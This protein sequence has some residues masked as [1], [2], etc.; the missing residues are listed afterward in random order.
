SIPGGGGSS[1]FGLTLARHVD[2]V[3]RLAQAGALL[4][5]Q[6]RFQLAEQRLRL[7]Q[8]LPHRQRA[9][10]PAAGG[11]GWIV[12]QRLVRALG[13]LVGPDGLLA[14]QRAVI[15]QE[16]V[17]LLRRER[18]E[19]REQRLQAVDAA[20]GRVDR[21]RG[22]LPVLLDDLEPRRAVQVAVHLAGQ[23]H[24]LGE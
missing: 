1:R 14:E 15:A 17:H 23:R 6:R 9:R 4:V 5:Y 21:G 12:G 18:Q 16:L 8:G 22:S 3:A 20:Q 24:R 11:P 2:V 19:R 13:F 7:A 10:L